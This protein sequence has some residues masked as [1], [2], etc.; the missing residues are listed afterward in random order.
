MGIRTGIGTRLGIGEESTWGTEASR[1]V[2]AR[3]MSTSLQRRATFVPLP[4]LV[5][6]TGTSRVRAEKYQSGERTGG[7]I[8]IVA[9]YEGNALGILLKHALGGLSDGGGG[10]PTYTHTFTI[11]DVLPTGLSVELQR[12]MDG[13]S[14]STAEEMYG[15]RVQSWALECAAGGAMEF[16]ATLIGKTGQARATQSVPSLS[17]ALYPILH[18]HAGQLAFNSNNYTIAKFKLSGSNKLG[19]I[20]ELGSQYLSDPPVVDFA[21][22]ML[23]CEVVSRSDQLYVEQLAGTQGDV[24]LTWTDSVNTK[25]LAM[26]MHN[27]VLEEDAEDISGPGEI[28]LR[29]RWRLFSA[30]SESGL[31]LVITNG[32]SSGIAA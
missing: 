15:C 25:T 8:K 11:A 29:C 30:S 14:A 9:C 16:A 26:T 22:L 1:T 21:D 28:R 20:Q 3:L 7:D 10:G 17:S 24:T 12:G 13:S 23:E 32:T 5:G 27:G 6:S 2:T 18:A 19:E 4:H 31:S